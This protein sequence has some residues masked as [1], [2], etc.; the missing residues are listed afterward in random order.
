MGLSGRCDYPDSRS[1]KGPS[2]GHSCVSEAE[3][4]D[5]RKA[6]EKRVI[7]H[8]IIILTRRSRFI[9]KG[10]RMDGCVRYYKLV[11]MKG[12]WVELGNR[13]SNRTH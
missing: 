3:G 7:R 9:G 10:L 12:L 11:I 4:S 6:A 5:C 8:M 1:C 13:N 2:M